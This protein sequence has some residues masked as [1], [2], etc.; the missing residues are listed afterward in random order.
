MSLTDHLTIRFSDDEA[1][2]LA[3]AAAFCREQSPSARVRALT[4]TDPGFDDAVWRQTAELGWLGI[5]VPERLGGAGLGLGTVA[6][7]VVEPMGRHLLA[8]P[9]VSTQLALQG[10]LA[11]DRAGQGDPA[12]AW[13]PRLVQ[14]QAATVAL[15]ED[16]G[17]WSLGHPAAR[18][19]PEAGGGWRL[20]GEKTLVTD[21]A[22]AAVLLV[23][24]QAPDGALALAVLPREALPDGAVQRE[25]V[26][27]ETRRVH[28]L[29]LDGVRLPAPALVT[30]AAAAQAVAAIERAGW[31]LAAAEATGGLAGA[32]AVVV[33]YLNTR[34][35]FGRKIGSYQGLKHPTADM[36][37]ALER[38]RSLVAHAA[39]LANQADQPDQAGRT[40]PSGPSCPAD[41]TATAELTLAA[42]MAK[43]EAGDSLLWAGDRAVQF[44]GGF[45]F[46][47]D[48]DAQLY[49]RRA[50]WLSPWFGD[51]AHHRRRI[52]DALWP[53]AA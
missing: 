46:T 35:A 11:A 25:T 16:D 53:L 50:L 8:T 20:A 43:A 30:G 23:S 13:V 47:Y 31:L 51:A 1:M 34:S 10:L 49:L 27:D 19:E 12:Q 17:D 18:A 14:G 7:A 40:G 3:S 21:A 9:F 45:G 48:C 6:T 4:A 36:L 32:L 28:R 24:V 52:A 38:C 37:V 22:V 5:A 33:D 26:A 41:A 29:R 15:F 42:R 44:H 2:L 39:T